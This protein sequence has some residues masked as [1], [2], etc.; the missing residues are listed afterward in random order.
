MKQSVFNLN[1]LKAHPE[2]NAFDLS[3]NDVFSCAPGMLL[4]ISCTEVLPSEHYEINPQIF[5]RTMPLNSAAFVRMRQHI[6]FFFVPMRV[7]CRQFNQF[8]VGT[9]Y[10]ISAL[11]ALND[12]NKT[13]PA[14]RLNEI[15]K[16]FL[17]TKSSD[18]LNIPLVEGSRRLFDLL[19]Y[20][21][22]SY[23]SVTEN[24][25]PD[26]YTQSNSDV[27]QNSPALSVFRLAAYQKVYQDYYRNPYWEAPDASAFNFDD[28]FGL[29]LSSTSDAARMTKLFTIRYRNWAKDFFTSI[30]P[31]FQGAPFVTKPIDMSSFSMYNSA[32]SQS[33]EPMT[34]S[35]M[36]FGKGD[37]SSSPFSSSVLTVDSK[38]TQT[39]GFNIPIHNIRA[40]FALDKLYRLQQQAGNGSYAEQIRNRFGFGGVHDDWKATYIGGSS[41]P[42]SIGEVITTANTR[43][44]VEGDDT[45]L[46]QTGDI[47]GKAS[48]VN[49]A[50]I[51]FDTKEHGII[52]GI[53]SVTPDADYNAS[54]IDPHNFK[55]NFQQFYQPEFDR[56][57]HQPLNTYY[58]SSTSISSVTSSVNWL[59]RVIGFQNRYLEYK[60]G[61]DKVHGQFCSGGT[62]SAWTAPR[63]SG[64]IEDTGGDMFSTY[65]LKVSPKILNSICS[66]AFDGN[67]YTDPILVDSH[68]GIK[69]I[70]P[71]SVSDEPLL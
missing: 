66:V 29:C 11:D 1:T 70:R 4:P 47:Y 17:A 55:L 22:S 26:S 8:V 56:L 45:I 60:T 12:F 34:V 3:H 64:I 65:S 67:D 33:F 30:Q 71:M 35:S 32:S 50:R 16:W 42:V 40:A 15:R 36:K 13:L 48:S 20:G 49:D 52:M 51:T 24:N 9:R 61:I 38:T 68:I 28:K 54:G 63:N 62:L 31:S 19:G 7:L 39:G 59:Q 53:F 5:L 46:G 14:V 6:E 44:G 37:L 43:L 57:G 69:A 27:T 41:S 58:L 21:I 18:G 2:R 23:R 10:A 25:Y